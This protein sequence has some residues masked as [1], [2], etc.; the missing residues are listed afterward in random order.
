VIILATTPRAVWYLTRGAGA[1]AL[2][3]LTLTVALGIVEARRWHVTGWPR[4]VLDALHRDLALISL[5]VLALHVLTAVVDTFAPIKL[6][7]AFLPL[8]SRYR[9]LWLGLGAL[10]FD[11]LLALIITSLLRRRLGYRA[12]R[13]VHWAAYACWPLALVHGLGSGTDAPTA[14]MLVLTVACAAAVALAVLA[15]VITA[16]RLTPGGRLAAGGAVAVVAIALAAWAAQGP[17]RAGWA[18]RAGTPAALLAKAP[19]PA[20]RAPAHPAPAAG[21][22]AS[23]RA[24][25]TGTILRTV[26]PDRVHVVVELPLTIQGA[27]S[28]RIDVRLVGLPVPGGGV[29]MQSSAVTLGPAPQPALYRGRIA[30]LAG[31]RMVAVVRSADGRA[32]RLILSLVPRDGGGVGGTVSARRTA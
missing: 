7:D 29:T 16:P 6:A 25:V 32:E 30:A 23:F 24:G 8:V 11:L 12:W 1:V 2:V 20:R 17:L 22:P 26:A 10:A 21:L 13:G 4:F 27:A 14:W 15:R 9:P 3:G 18:R 5:A 19:A 28:G 31:T